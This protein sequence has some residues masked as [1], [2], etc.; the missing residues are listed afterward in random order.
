MTIERIL[1]GT[2][3]VLLG[4]FN[5]AIFHPSWL[6]AREVESEFDEGIV[7]VVHRDLSVIEYDTRIYNVQ[8]NRFSLETSTTPGVEV[9]DKTRQIFQDNL[10]HT[11]INAI[12]INRTVHFSVGSQAARTKLGRKLSP[13]TPW[14]QFGKQMDADDAAHT[15]GLKSLTMKS[16][17]T[18]N[19][20]RIETN[21]RI[22]PSAKVP[23]E[24]G[25]YMEVNRHF[26]LQDY[27]DLEG[28]TRS[29]K[30]LAEHFRGSLSKAD[31]IIQNM[32]DIVENE[33]I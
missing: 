12:G 6:T 25:V 16:I 23:Q 17:E 15:G 29:M 14:G 21:A 8:T 4:K 3:V 32:M 18:V 19:E 31:E 28:A 33:N 26:A 22:E 2:S 30:V 24:S 20:L 7:K 10:I 13:I 9:A 5:P 11:P 1:Q 27:S